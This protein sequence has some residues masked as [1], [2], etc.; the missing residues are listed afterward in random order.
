MFGD[1]DDDQ[2]DDI[3]TPPPSADL[4]EELVTHSRTGE[5]EGTTFVTE[6]QDD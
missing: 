2:P 1:D 4:G 6:S 5:D 3:P